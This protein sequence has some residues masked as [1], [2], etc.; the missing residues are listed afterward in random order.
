MIILYN[1][2]TCP[3]CRRVREKLQELGLE[4]Q[5]IDVPKAKSERR[6]V[7]EISGQV[8][9]PVLVDGDVIIADDD[10]QAIAYLEEKYGKK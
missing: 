2:E 1:L 6:Q 4:Y 10:D 3:Y 7:V 9:V 8:F 5:K